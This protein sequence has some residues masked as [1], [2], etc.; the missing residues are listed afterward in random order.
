M[1]FHSETSLS[2]MERSRKLIK[3]RVYALFLVSLF[4]SSS[5]SRKTILSIFQKTID[6][7]P[8]LCGAFDDQKCGHQTRPCNQEV[9]HQ[10][11]LQGGTA[12]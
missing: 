12:L 1:Y 8:K 4:S 5:T 3:A 7:V 10:N 6:I 11:Q 2:V 9:F